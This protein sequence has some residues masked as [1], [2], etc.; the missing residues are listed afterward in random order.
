MTI[1]ELLRFF[2]GYGT[3]DFEGFVATTLGATV[4]LLAILL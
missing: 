3:P 2:A 4:A 1:K